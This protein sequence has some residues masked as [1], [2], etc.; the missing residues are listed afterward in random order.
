MP[1]FAHA[2][3][4][5]AA[6]VLAAGAFGNVPGYE[7]IQLQVRSNFSVNP[8]GSYNIPGDHFFGSATPALN[9]NGQVSVLIGTIA[10]SAAKKVW[11]GGGG[12]G[13]LVYTSPDDAFLSDVA[14]NNA[15][16][17]VFPQDFVSPSGVIF[18]DTAAGNTNG[19]AVA[20]GGPYG[21]S[22]FGSPRINASGQIG[23]RGTNGFGQSFVSADG[24][25]QARH[26]TEASVD[27]ASPY[28][29][30]FTPSFN[31]NRQIAGKARRGAQGET[32]GSQPDEIRIWNA[33][34]TSVLIAEDRDSDPAS[35]YTSFDNSVSLNNRGQVAFAANLAAGGRGIFLSDGSTTVQIAQSGAGGVG[36]IEFFSPVVNDRGA[37][38]FRSFDSAGLR[39]VWVGDGES[40]RKI[41]TEH[42]LVP[43]DQGTAR[44]DQNDSAPT[45]GG[46]V[47]INYCGDVAFHATL[48]PPDN[49]QIE[50]GSGIFVAF[51][52]PSADFDGDGKLSV[53]DFSAFRTAYLSGDPN[54]DFDCDRQLSVADFTAFRAAYLGG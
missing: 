7:T 5:A 31:D 35:P 39:A 51:A 40:L 17:I 1:K 43:T 24:A 21:I 34:G 23:Y 52:E 47:S 49:N 16:R 53:A 54:A 20:P 32:G 50:W 2:L 28:S 42:D 3:P 15:G 41:V 8:G 25:S 38:A 18:V 11:F 46:G 13:G 30:L 22:G 14:I 26:V 12:S 4:A 48:T 19:V 45:F 29:F 37:V 6:L 27:A 36:N 44:I 10:G 9:D 33:D